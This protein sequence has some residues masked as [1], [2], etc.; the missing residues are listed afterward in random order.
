MSY[1]SPRRTESKIKNIL[2]SIFKTKKRIFI[3]TAVALLI[4]G[5][6][7]WIFSS[8]SLKRTMALKTAG[9]ISKIVQLFPIKDD[10]KKEL[11]VAN[12]IAEEL[13]KKDNQERV[14]LVLLQNSMELRPGGGFLGQ[15]AIIKIKNGEVVS[16]F[17]EDGNLADQRITVNVP[18]PYPFKQMLQVKK[19]KF[20]NS[21]FSPDFSINAEKAKYFLRLSGR[22]GNFDGVIAV[23]SNVL[24][25]ILELTGPITVPGY[26]KVFNKDNAILQLEDIVEKPYLMNS[27]LDTQN[28]KSILKSMANVIIGK[29]STFGNISK[30]TEFAHN[31][32]KNKEVMVSFK[33]E[34]LQKMIEEVYWSGK[35]ANDW[36]GDYLMAVDANMGALK[37]DYYMKR[38][39]SYDVDLTAEKPV[40]TLNILYKNNA[41]SGNWRTSDYH[42]YLRVYAPEGSQ[43]LERKMVGSP[44]IRN[45]LGKTY[46]GVKVD[47]LIGRETPAMIK[48][49]LP[50]R[51]KTEPYR[52]LIQKQSGMSDVPVKVNI[53]TKDGIFEYSD[54]LKKDLKFEVK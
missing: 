2:K 54:I 31:E 38:E 10:I 7:F 26:A 15:Y 37:T 19:W 39:M 4:V 32:L 13:T 34:R 17:V 44:M 3:F 20:T 12:A 11:E 46:F 35:V 5:F 8:D 47:V 21:N 45:E 1:F 33:D 30:L 49:N 23:N 52:L 41:P 43:F 29:L 50:D 16:T 48:Y 25:H 24:N 27:D 53:K 40:A 36:G 9:S 42:S 6:L 51:F 22:G 18:A 14:Y 28:R